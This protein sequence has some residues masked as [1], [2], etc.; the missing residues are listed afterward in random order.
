M[1]ET[2]LSRL[3]GIRVLGASWLIATLLL[4]VPLVLPLLVAIAIM[5]F[6]SGMCNT[7]GNTVSMTLRQRLIPSALLGRVFGA[8]QTINLGLIPFGTILAGIIAH[9]AGMPAWLLSA[10]VLAS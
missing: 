6:I 10:T 7:I 4:I 8:A 2:L 5:L 1:L 9:F 3:H